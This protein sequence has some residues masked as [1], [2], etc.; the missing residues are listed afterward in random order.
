MNTTP[1]LTKT[2]REQQDTLY[3]IQ[4]RGKP[5]EPWEDTYERTNI[6]TVENLYRSLNLTSEDNL[7]WRVIK[8]VF[9]EETQETPLYF[10]V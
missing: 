2:Y 9:F 1:G 6:E 8:R 3:I 10:H 7:K 5:S 4:Y